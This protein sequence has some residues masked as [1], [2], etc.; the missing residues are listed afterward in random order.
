MYELKK[1]FFFYLYALI[2]LELE[3]L[4]NCYIQIGI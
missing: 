4:R 2:Y 1:S 3:K